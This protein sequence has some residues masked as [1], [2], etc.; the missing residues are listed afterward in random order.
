[1]NDKVRAKTA[2]GTLVQ[3][4]KWGL[5]YLFNIIATFWYNCMQRGFSNNHYP[6][7]TEYNMWAVDDRMQILLSPEPKYATGI[8]VQVAPLNS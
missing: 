5:E 1:M 7:P 4:L 6:I 2:L 3:S 8:L